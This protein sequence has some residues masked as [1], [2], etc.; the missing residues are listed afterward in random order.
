MKVKNWI[1]GKP[2]TI[3]REALLQDALESLSFEVSQAVSGEEALDI[4]DQPQEKPFELIFMDWKMPGLDGIETSKRIKK[5]T[6]FQ[7]PPKIIM[8]TAY[9]GE[10]VMTQAQELTLDGFLVKPVTPSSLLNAIMEAFG[11]GAKNQN[12]RKI[13]D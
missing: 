8:L 7:P 13:R 5:K 1:H 4:L 6:I 9:G 2:I 10:E 12:I 11:K 3:D